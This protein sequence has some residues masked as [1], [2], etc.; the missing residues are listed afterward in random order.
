MKY[1]NLI[2]KFIILL[3]IVSFIN[4]N[5]CQAKSFLQTDNTINNSDKSNGIKVLVLSY[6]PDGSIQQ[7]II[8]ISKISFASMKTDLQNTKSINEKLSIYKKY[9]LVPNNITVEQLREGM[10]TKSQKLNLTKE[11]YDS[12]L[13]KK[14]KH[15]EN[16]GLFKT[17]YVN[18]N[19]T[20]YG[21]GFFNLHL[22]M[23]TTPSLMIPN[24]FI[25]LFNIDTWGTDITD[26]IKSRDIFDVQKFLLSEIYSLDG[27]LPDYALR[28]V[29]TM[30][31]FIG[32]VGYI[33]IFYPLPL[34]SMYEEF[35]GFT[36][37]SYVGGIVY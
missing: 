20:M 21:F 13:L 10:F 7:S 23:G 2:K 26:L 18:Y 37:F 29:L 11:T 3:L 27:T 6:Q 25:F 5:L 30:A 17:R 31:I 1:R 36:A 24:F 34:I 32:F 12:L 33:L 8:K 4:I 16:S 9:S 14:F 28:S 35:L 15:S 22:S 19:C